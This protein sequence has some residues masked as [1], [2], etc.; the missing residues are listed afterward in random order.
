M[1][2][3]A[4]YMVPH[5]P[6]IIPEVG[7][8]GEKRIRS[9]VKAYD[10]VG[11]D[12]G[13]LKPDTVIITSP[14][15]VMYADY[16]HIS[17]G[18]GA[19]GSFA[20]FGAP[21]A[22]FSESYDTELVKTI[23]S[24]AESELF[25][26]GTLGERDKKLDHGTLVPLHFIRNYLDGFRIVRIGLSAL[27]LTKH[28]QLGKLINAA[29]EKLGRR[30]VFV[31]SG[32]LSHKLREDGPYGYSPQGEEY[33]RR[34]MDV[35]SRGAFGELFDFD[36][37]LRE[38]AAECGHGSLVIMAGALDGMS[39]RAERLSHEDV[40][41]VG[42]GI[43]SFVPEGPDESRRFLDARLSEEERRVSDKAASSDAYAALARRAVEEYV[44]HGK[45][46]QLPRDKNTQMT[47][48]KAGA[49]VS[50]HEHGALRGC[51][52]TISPVRSCIGEE[53]ISNAISAATADPR[54]RPIGPEEL[55][56]LEISV[57]ILS[58]PEEIDSPDR[59]DVKRYGVIVCSGSKRGVLLP[60][61]E[62]VDT[63]EQ[64]ID[65]ARQKAGIAPGKKLTLYRFT[66]SRHS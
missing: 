42:Y 66:V 14:H 29:V 21:R 58:E 47:R 51:I 6:L 10:T 40:T 63:V 22:R 59:L 24:M 3:V 26:A 60:D 9:T 23:E 15:S 8:G 33:E 19:V 43:C 20:D 31:A 37:D 18:S 54:F 57:D 4:A 38:R 1:S 17:P 12:I 36:E 52:G 5:P 46:L 13:R 30:A 2:I 65:I 44:L 34:I 49:F 35:C 50:I 16:F 64:Q 45:R 62:G 41:G 55:K 39:V 61:L 56:W 53:I 28:Y 32:D 7:R 11:R 48:A 27:P 25:P